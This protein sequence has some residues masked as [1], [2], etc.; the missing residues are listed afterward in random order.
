MN[1]AL[2]LSPEI[3]SGAPDTRKRAIRGKEN[4]AS[5]TLLLFIPHVNGKLKP[6]KR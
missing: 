1:R 4:D 5:G 2:T 6:Q 3:A